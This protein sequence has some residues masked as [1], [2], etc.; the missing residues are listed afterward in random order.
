MGVEDLVVRQL[1]FCR[2]KPGKRVCSLA[3][4]MA[5][6]VLTF[7]ISLRAQSADGDSLRRVKTAVTP[8]YSPLAKRLN[9]IGVVKVSV[10]IAPDGKVKQA[11]VIGGHPV[12]AVEAE[13]AALLTR[14][15]PGPKETTQIIEFRFGS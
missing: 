15:E 3:L 1:S 9:L 4:L 12:L 14:F 10:V 13:K 5:A 11:H 2:V 6:L 7:G 8:E